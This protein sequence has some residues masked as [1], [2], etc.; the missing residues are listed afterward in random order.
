M[1]GGPCGLE[2][3]TLVHGHVHDHRAGS[4]AAE[5]V[6]GDQVGGPGALDQHGAD[7]QVG[8]V[9]GRLQL[10]LRGVHGAYPAGESPGEGLQH[11][12]GAVQHGYVG[13]QADG[14]LGSV[15]TDHAATYDDDP[16]RAHA[17]HA[18]QQQSCTALGGLQGVGP[19]LDRHASGDC[20]HRG[21]QR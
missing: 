9:N 11:G 17:G 13:A 21:Q 15:L 5:H 19:G 4:H 1:G 6:A 10:G 3:A 16:A 7:H 14:H 20:R 2:A 12:G 18:A 8:V